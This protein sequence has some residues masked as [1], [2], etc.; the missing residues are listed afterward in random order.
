MVPS[1]VQ[2]VISSASTNTARTLAP[3]SFHPEN[4]KT[5]SIDRIID[6]VFFSQCSANERDYW[7]S[8]MGLKLDRK[9]PM[10]S[11][12]DPATTPAQKYSQFQEGL[13]HVLTISKDEL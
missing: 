11:K 7:I 12:L 1:M 3:S 13:R 6:E 9:Y 2:R 4:N 10:K 8:K 5:A